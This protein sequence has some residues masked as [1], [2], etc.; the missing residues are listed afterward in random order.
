[1]YS[2]MNSPMVE[3]RMS[4]SLKAIIFDVDGVLIDSLTKHLE[5]CRAEASALGLNLAIPDPDAFRHMVQLG[6][7]VSPMEEFFR[8][9]KFPEPVIARAVSDY[10]DNFAKTHS[11]PIFDGV[12]S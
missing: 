12:N 9:V 2:M 4:G 5:F 8:A 10:N 7:K 3:G 6:T 11:P 1:M